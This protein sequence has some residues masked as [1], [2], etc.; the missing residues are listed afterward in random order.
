MNLPP[1][2]WGVFELLKPVA[3]RLEMTPHYR[4][5]LLGLDHFSFAWR[6]SHRPP[7]GSQIEMP[8]ALIVRMENMG[9]G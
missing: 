9:V 4:L 1:V 7:A 2:F 5:E 6:E 8:G 3:E